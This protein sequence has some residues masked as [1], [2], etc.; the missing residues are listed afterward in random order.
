[1]GHRSALTGVLLLLCAGWIQAA[2][3]DSFAVRLAAAATT[4]L[5]SNVR[6]DGRYYAIA[7]PGGD[8]P[9]EVGVC[10]DVVIRAYRALGFDLQRAVHEDMAAHFQLY[11]SRRI[12]GLTR[13]DPNIDHRRVPNLQVFFSRFG[14]R[15]PVTN[16]GNDYM[17]GDLVTWM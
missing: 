1:M 5:E 15:L 11:P 12:W 7:Y 6:Y 14:E 4:Q 16:A 13:P 17:V 9:P 10:T 8:V 2:G 3:A